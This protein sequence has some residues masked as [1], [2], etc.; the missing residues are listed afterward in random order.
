MQKGIYR[1]EWSRGRE[2]RGGPGRQFQELKGTSARKER[3]ALYHP[4][5]TGCLL[6]THDEVVS[7]GLWIVPEIPWRPQRVV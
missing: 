7:L 3:N 5:D 4:G 6:E 2:T 1:E